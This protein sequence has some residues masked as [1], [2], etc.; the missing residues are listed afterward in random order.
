MSSLVSGTLSLP[1]SMVGQ[2]GCVSSVV[3][4][5]KPLRLMVGSVAVISGCNAT[6]FR[7]F[8][9]GG[10]IGSLSSVSARFILSPMTLAASTNGVSSARAT[11][12]NLFT[13][14]PYHVIRQ[15]VFIPGVRY[16]SMRSQLQRAA[17]FSPGI[18]TWGLKDAD[19]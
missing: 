17:I 16:A 19:Q 9:L 10:S 11:L 4:I 1:H 3:G 13:P 14:G 18:R 8:D 12:S 2:V 6:M 7:T 15:G 5:L